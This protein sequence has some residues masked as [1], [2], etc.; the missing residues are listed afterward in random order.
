MRRLK[1]EEK[2]HG[3]NDLRKRIDGIITGKY[4]HT[5]YQFVY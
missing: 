2:M 3:K 5:I 4:V 1:K